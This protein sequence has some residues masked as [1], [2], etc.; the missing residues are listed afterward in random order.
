MGAEVK[1]DM[2]DSEVIYPGPARIVLAAA[3]QL[4]DPD[5]TERYSEEWLANLRHRAHLQQWRD[6]V[7]LLLRGA[8]TTRWAYHGTDHSRSRVVIASQVTMAL[9]TA[10]GT[11]L[12]FLTATTTGTG[13]DPFLTWRYI[14]LLTLWVSLTAAG[15]TG[16]VLLTRWSWRAV[17]G[18]LAFGFLII[19]L[20]SSHILPINADKFIL[21][22]F[23]DYGYHGFIMVGRFV[24]WRA[25]V[26]TPWALYAALTLFVH[27]TPSPVMRVLA[28]ANVVA[29]LNVITPYWA[30]WYADQ[31]GLV[32][33]IRLMS[34]LLNLNERTAVQVTPAIGFLLGM[35]IVV[36]AWRCVVIASSLILPARRGPSGA[37]ICPR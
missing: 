18:W 1:G 24:S 28:A 9:V 15:V 33:L 34:G 4:R 20:A 3:A 26:V 25:G 27:R 22:T 17:L 29:I 6:A 35:F 19:I 16:L 36:V 32:D 2:R 37:W 12:L 31:L 8:R 10:A 21:F 11:V 14:D 5:L 23:E 30:Y 13:R 7:S